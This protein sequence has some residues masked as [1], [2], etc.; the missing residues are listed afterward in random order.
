MYKV[1]DSVP[2]VASSKQKIVSCQESQSLPKF[3]MKCCECLKGFNKAVITAKGNFFGG[4]LAKYCNFCL[5]NQKL[6]ALCFLRNTFAVAIYLHKEV[7]ENGTSLSCDS[8]S[9]C[10][11]YNTPDP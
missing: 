2:S 10:L 6:I 5:I 8:G 4:R 11:I 9:G 3:K 7:V 1:Y